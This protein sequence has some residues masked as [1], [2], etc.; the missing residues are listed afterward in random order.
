MSYNLRQIK[1]KEIKSNNQIK[2]ESNSQELSSSFPSSFKIEDYSY[3]KIKK[4]IIEDEEDKEF[5]KTNKIKEQR[6]KNNKI[7]NLEISRTINDIIQRNENN[8]NNNVYSTNDQESSSS[9]PMSFSNFDE[10]DSDYNYNESLNN[11]E[12][13]LEENNNLYKNY[14]NRKRKY[15]KDNDDISINKKEEKKMIIIIQWK[16]FLTNLTLKLKNIK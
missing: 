6:E 15:E 14:I 7:K 5:I 8:I 16:T 1:S 13:L 10:L 12:D 3:D 11:D 9:A 2:S 4:L